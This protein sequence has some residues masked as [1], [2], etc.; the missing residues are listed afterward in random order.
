MVVGAVVAALVAAGLITWWD[1][2]G[3]DGTQTA[4]PVV[5]GAAAVPG[6]GAPHPVSGGASGPTAVAGDGTCPLPG[7]ELTVAAAPELADTLTTAAHTLR[8]GGCLLKVRAADPAAVIADTAGANAWIPDS[9]V[10]LERAAAAGRAVP[11]QGTS[12]ATSPVVLAVSGAAARQLQQS[13]GSDMRGILASRAG[14]TPIR[15]GL[16]DPQR[17]A[18]AVGAI[19]SA[20]AAVTG[21]ADARAALTW[22]VRS[23][24][25]DLPTSAAELLARLDADPRTALPVGEQQV[26][27]YNRT[28]AGSPAVAV[29]ERTGGV[30]L[31]YPLVALSPDPSV[32]AVTAA[33]AS[34]LTGG[35]GRDALLQAGFRGVDGKAGSAV[36]DVPGVDPAVTIA[37]PLPALGAVDEAIRT[38]QL[39]NEPSRMLAVMDISGSME[40]EVPGAGG[41]SRM[42]VAKAAA[43]RGLALYPPTSEI[44]LWVFSRKL[45]GDT[46]HRELIPVGPLGADADGGSGAQRLAAA[47][48]GIQAVPDGGTGLYDTVLDAVRTMR[49]AWDPS[50]VNAVLILSDGMNDDQGSISLDDLLRMLSAEQDPQRPVP[51]ISIAFGPDSDVQALAAISKATGGAAYQSRDPNQIGEIFL[52]AVGQR[53]CRPGC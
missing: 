46:D 20:R 43:A 3:A 26:I 25:A 1:R 32:T 37:D 13:G 44:G 29:Y 7:G 16:P 6:T 12:I 9:S 30:A 11:G 47:V 21:A 41:A 17:S 19:L 48:A 40:S 15:V 24:P 36:G 14:A 8:P 5:S 22:A 28:H 52:D 35:P 45:D 38:A 10:W 27:A 33:L 34:A 50:K 51:V 23:S 39:T 4:A 53:L 31:D 2:T 49:A 42:D 18:A